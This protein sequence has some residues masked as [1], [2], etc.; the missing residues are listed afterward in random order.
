MPDW[1]VFWGHWTILLTFSEEAIPFEGTSG[2]EVEQNFDYCLSCLFL[3]HSVSGREMEKK[4]RAQTSL[5][6]WEC[7]AYFSFCFHCVEMSLTQSQ[8]CMVIY[9]HWMGRLRA[10]WG[11]GSLTTVEHPVGLVW[12]VLAK[13]SFPE[14][15]WLCDED[16]FTSMVAESSDQQ[17][18]CL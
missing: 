5:F 11:D 9:A 18:H 10:S 2:K 8:W 15:C 3:G 16:I 17:S 7:A 1:D 12:S 14:Y 6:F 4:K 13:W